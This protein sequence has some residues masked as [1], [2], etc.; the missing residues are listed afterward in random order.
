[1]CLSRAGDHVD[2]GRD[3]DAQ[4]RAG[5]QRQQRH[6]VAQVFHDFFDTGNCN[7]HGRYG[8][9]HAPVAFVFHQQQ[10]AGF[11]HGEVDA[12]DAD[13]RF[14]EFLPQDFA[15]DLNELVNVLGVFHAKFVVEQGR[16]L[17][18]VLVDCR[19]DYV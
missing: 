15:T 5:Q 14:E 7:V 3:R 1:M 10:G 16:D 6:H 8:G 9:G 4:G 11:G 17:T 13:V 2:V 12:G 18:G 19:H